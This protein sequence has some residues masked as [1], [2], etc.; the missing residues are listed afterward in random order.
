MTGMLWLLDNLSWFEED[1]TTLGPR[2]KGRGQEVGLSRS[3]DQPKPPS[4][5]EGNGADDHS[6]PDQGFRGL[7]E[8]V[9]RVRPRAKGAGLTNPKVF[10]SVGDANETV[11]VFDVADIASGEHVRHQSRT[12]GGDASAGV[13]D[14]PTVYLVEE[15][16]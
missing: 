14:E 4:T 10:R 15:A 7:E 13:L 8:G 9:R 6:P 12:Q 3:I 2:V 1:S 16:R 5:G 11:I